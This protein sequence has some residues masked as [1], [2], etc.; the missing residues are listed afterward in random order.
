MQYQVILMNAHTETLI[1]T[2]K[3]TSIEQQA[4][5]WKRVAEDLERS[6]RQRRVVNVFKIDLHCQDGDVV[7]VPGK[8]L[9]NGDL[10]KKVTVAAFAFSTEAKNKIS[11][12]GKA[13]TIQELM[14]TNPK[15]Q[16]VKILG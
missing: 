10:T 4:A 7:V 6:S 2:L 1:Q 12:A 11:K 16:R 13:L 3:R 8:V 5:V 9:G 15:G 14:K